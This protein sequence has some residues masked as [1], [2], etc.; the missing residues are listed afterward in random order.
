[1]GRREEV[2]A[3][4][5]RVAATPLAGLP[6]PDSISGQE[7]P[8]FVYC[9]VSARCPP[10]LDDPWRLRISPT[11]NQKKINKPHTHMQHVSSHL[12]TR[13]THAELLG[14]A[15]RR[16]PHDDPQLPSRGMPRTRAHQH[17]LLLAPGL[18]L[19][20]HAPGGPPPR[21]SRGR[22]RGGSRRFLMKIRRG[23]GV[24][25]CVRVP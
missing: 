3:C 18:A 19:P 21:R 16:A 6:M 12:P 15:A 11:P 25:T 13:R 5:S 20:R 1:M 17:R 8:S 23:S 9:Q 7:E 24:V 2:R 22:A 10:S 14:L 4:V